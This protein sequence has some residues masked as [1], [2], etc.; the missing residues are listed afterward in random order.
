[1]LEHHDI[2]EIKVK[3]HLDNRWAQRFEGL[4]M[5]L[6]PGGET[7]LSGPLPDQAALHSV[8]SRIRDLG[9]PLLLVRQVPPEQAA[10]QPDEMPR[11]NG[12]RQEELP[13]GS[14]GERR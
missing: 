1:M 3:G 8:L 13:E 5:T 6:L 2:Y 14:I 4:A 9:V 11:K 12:S 7:L 10:P